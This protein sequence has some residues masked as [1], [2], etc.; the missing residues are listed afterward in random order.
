V[1]MLREKLFVARLYKFDENLIR[2]DG[3]SHKEFHLLYILGL[4][5]L[6]WEACFGA[7]FKIIKY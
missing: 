1:Y 5:L 6:K 4:T 3:G 2:S 7:F